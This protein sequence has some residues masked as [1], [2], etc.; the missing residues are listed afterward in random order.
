MR[1]GPR[2]VAVKHFAEEGRERRHDLFEYLL[3]LFHKIGSVAAKDFIIMT[4]LRL[5]L[6]TFRV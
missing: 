3:Y 6:R 1:Q 4:P 2:Q 5:E